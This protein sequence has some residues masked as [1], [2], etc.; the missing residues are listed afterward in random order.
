MKIRKFTEAFI[1]NPGLFWSLMIGI[2]LAGIYA[3]INVPKLED[4]AVCGKQA[5][6]IIIYPGASAHQ[7][8]L[9]AAQVVEDGLRTL[10]D[11][12]ELRTECYNGMAQI[13]VEFEMTVLNKDLEQHFDLLRRKMSEVRLPQGCYP[14]VVVDDMM[15]TYGIF[16]GLKSDGYSYPEMLRYAKMLRR[17]ILSVKG[18]K[19]V[20]IV[21]QRDEVI[22]ITLSREK[23][24]RNG[25][26]P[27]QIMMA[28]QNVGREVNAGKYRSDSDL[29]QLRVGGR[30][31]NERDIR[32][33]MLKSV[34]GKLFRL[35]DVADVQRTY[36]EPQTRGFFVDGKPALAICVTMNN[37]VIVPD[38]GKAVDKTVTTAMK[39]VPVGLELKKIFFQ[40]DKVNEAISGFMV[41]LIE[42]VLIVILVLIFSMGFRSGL[43]IGTGLVLTIAVTFPL[44]L[45]CG[46][47]LQRIS[48]GAFIIAMGMLVDNSIVVMDGILMDRKRGTGPKTWLYRIGDQTAWP[49]LG[50]TVIAASTFIAV[51]LS[52]DTAGEYCRDMFLVLFFS[53]LASWLLAFIQVPACAKAWLTARDEGRKLMTKSEDTQSESIYN[54]SWHRAIRSVVTTFIGHKWTVLCVGIAVLLICCFGMTKVKNLFFPDFDYKQFIVEV[55]LP[56]QSSPD[57]VRQGL[58]QM[59]QEMLHDRRVTQIAMS[60]GAAPAHYCLVRPMT[61]GGDTYGELM[62]D[63]RD[64]AAVEEAI[65][66]W[67]NRLRR[68]Y[69]DTYIRFRKYNFSVST[70]HTVQVIFKG[71]DPTV[72]RHLSAQAEAIMRKCKYVDAYS[73]ENN[74]RPMGKS[75]TAEYLS[76]NGVRSGI[77]RNNVAD[78]LL[79]A[80]DGLPVGA[81]A[82]GDKQLIVNL[83]VRNSNGSR[84]QRLQD[85]PVWSM[86]NVN[87]DPQRISGLLTGGTSADNLS[88]DMFRC[89]PL[90]TVAPNLKLKW[91]NDFVYRVNGQRAI[92]A[93]CD[94]NT[95]LYQGTTA[96]VNQEIKEDISKIALPEGY[97]MEWGGETKLQHDATANIL[98]FIPL[99]LVIILTILL[100]LF[101]SWRE[102]LLIV[103]M[104]PFVICGIV[105]SLLMFH[106]PFTFMAIVGMM[107]LMGMMIKNAIVLVDEINRLY[108]V[109]HYEPWRAVT[110]ATVSRVRPV[111]MASLTTILGMAPLLGDPMYGSMSICIMSG[112]TMGTIITLIFLPVVYSVMFKVRVNQQHV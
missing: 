80:T 15:D 56:D 17:E 6:V 34:D 19:R 45:V 89:V 78:A 58:Q 74:W 73:V 18:V 111:I 106:Q 39:R 30:L 7:V 102:V 108:K 103:S 91:E 37:D 1:K 24:S 28:L 101:K 86:M 76:D 81:V 10:P 60:M 109:E 96:K 5:Q 100:V 22:N 90:S 46:S 49:L 63:C 112:L 85:V 71:P 83:M 107:G 23:L 12:H 59:T 27:T 14:P 92:I 26:I 79:A 93:Q 65:P 55:F 25:L 13:T 16:Y 43:I 105:P 110:E 51:Y 84:I 21:G 77:H 54:S 99:T 20:N 67:R 52:P 104:I 48:L 2:L 87:L 9:K 35:G 38:V 95:S 70:S 82:E 3:Y 61:N 4:P 62:V 47:T 88:Q 32:N 98:K 36:T 42:S 64:F 44:L 33:M 57:R 72:L 8:E 53:L 41:N 31:D 50:A 94:P 75:V 66:Y 11:V 29:L 40:P 97:T 69:P 68:E